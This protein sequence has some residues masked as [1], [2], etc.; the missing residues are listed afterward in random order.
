MRKAFLGL[1]LG[2]VA[3]PA[4]VLAQDYAP[5]L[6]WRPSGDLDLWYSYADQKIQQTDHSPSGS[7]VGFSGQLN[8]PFYL[9]VEGK[10]QFNDEDH[11]YE[12]SPAGTGYG[13]SLDEQVRTGGGVQAY[14][15][16]VPMTIYAKADYVHYRYSSPDLVDDFG[17]VGRFHDNDDGAGYFAGFR[18]N[19]R[20]L[21]V[22]GEGGYLKLSD[23]HGQQFRGG[24]ALPLG[25]VIRHRANIELFA[26]YEWTRLHGN[27]GNDDAFNNFLP[28]LMY[29]YHVGIRMPFY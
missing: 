29:D 9:F 4:V 1:V 3:A 23:T 26:E 7:G 22:Y 17:N 20:W 13:M 6:F 28:G 21:Q 18:S 10:F 11:P 16:L 19:G 12:N 25:H 2:S 27:H 24:L 15:P 5:P 14:V 8:L